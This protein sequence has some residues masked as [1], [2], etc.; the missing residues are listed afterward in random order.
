[1]IFDTHCHYNLEPIFSGKQQFFPTKLIDPISQYNWQAHWQNAQQA[2]V[3]ASLVAGAD[4]D[5][6]KKAIEIA[7]QEKNLFASVGINPADFTNQ[8]LDQLNNDFGQLSTLAKKKEVVAIGECGIDY[9]RLSDSQRSS[10]Q[11]IQESIF[12]QH[13][14]LANSL[15]KP[16]IIHAR[17]NEKQAYDQ[18]LKLL[19]EHYLFEKP[20]VLHCVSGH[21]EYIKEALGMGAFISFAGNVTYPNAQELKNILKIVPQDRLLIETDAPFLP[22]QAKRGRV[23]LPEF[24]ALTATYLEQEHSVN[25]QQIFKNSLAFF[26][27]NKLENE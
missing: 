14:Q 20:F 21:I 25:L 6:S 10:Q 5:S 4:L 13:L 19:K 7:S 24:I 9:F 12:I 18:I 17:D 3:K 1:M 15:N 22:P 27:I 23:N 2:G 16:L 11:K 8:T 26:E